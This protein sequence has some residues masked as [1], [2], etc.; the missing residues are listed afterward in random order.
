MTTQVTIKC[1]GC[2]CNQVIE[3]RRELK[4]G[5]FNFGN[6]TMDGF[7]MMCESCGSTV[8]KVVDVSVST[9]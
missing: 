9:P 2:T 4:A 3:P 5:P 8:F 7:R 6:I 1:L